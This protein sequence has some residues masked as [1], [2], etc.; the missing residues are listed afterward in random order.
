MPHEIAPVFNDNL[1]R[2]LGG[3]AL[4]HVVDRRHGY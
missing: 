4:R 3:R 2:Y 1:A